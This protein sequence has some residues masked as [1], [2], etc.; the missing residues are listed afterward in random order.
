MNGIGKRI[1]M[2]QIR[3]RDAQVRKL[4][5]KLEDKGAEM[6]ECVAE[7]RRTHKRGQTELQEQL[8]EMR[9]KGMRMEAENAQ[10][11]CKLEAQVGGKQIG[12]GEGR[13]ANS[14]GL[15]AWKKVRKW[16]R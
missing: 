15:V 4:E 10:L 2:E 13:G 1:Q 8:E 14:G 11:R 6:E 3:A 9:R 12:E 16:K 5:R 7:L